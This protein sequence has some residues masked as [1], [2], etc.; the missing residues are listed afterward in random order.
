[1][2]IKNNKFVKIKIKNLNMV[3]VFFVFL[4]LLG[5]FSKLIHDTV[6]NIQFYMNLYIKDIYTCK[7]FQTKQCFIFL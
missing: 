1:M 2:I 5:G 7:E 3:G 4:E 6:L